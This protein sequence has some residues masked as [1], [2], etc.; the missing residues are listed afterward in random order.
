MRKTA[1]SRT[2]LRHILS[3]MD[4]WNSVALFFPSLAIVIQLWYLSRHVKNAPALM[5]QPK[6]RALS[7]W[8][9]LV[10]LIFYAFAAGNVAVVGLTS[11][12]RLYH[13]ALPVTKVVSFIR[14]SE[15]IYSE[16]WQFYCFLSETRCSKKKLQIAD[17]GLKRK[18]LRSFFF[19]HTLFASI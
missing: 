13:G 9:V 7:F 5:A 15:S 2:T 17:F 14:Y 1:V 19:V 12:C 8:L 18:L 6:G 10:S 11:S 16:R 3:L 4:A